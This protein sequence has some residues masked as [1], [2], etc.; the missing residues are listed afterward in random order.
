MS[1]L[2]ESKRILLEA[3]RQE[4]AVLGER[5]TEEIEKLRTEQRELHAKGLLESPQQQ[6]NAQLDKLRAGD[7]EIDSAV[8]RW[9]GLVASASGNVTRVVKEMQQFLIEGKLPELR[10][11]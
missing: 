9:Q 6:I 8:N 2:T 3:V 11:K 5:V 4:I 7:T 10:K 1:D